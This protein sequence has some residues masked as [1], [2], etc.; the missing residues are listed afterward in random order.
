MD[1]MRFTYNAYKQSSILRFDGNDALEKKAPGSV[2][3]GIT[4]RKIQV[5]GDVVSRYGI[6]WSGVMEKAGMGIEGIES[7]CGA[8]ALRMMLRR[9]PAASS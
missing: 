9:M 3:M 7:L 5:F 1:R 8:S 2:C 6:T 4:S